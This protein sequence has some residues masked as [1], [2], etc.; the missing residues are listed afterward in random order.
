MSTGNPTP[1]EA[2][3]SPPPRRR[4]H[5]GRWL[6]WGL[7]GLL[8]LVLVLVVGALIYATGPAGEA[9]IRALAIEQA[10]KQLMGR[11]EIGGLDLSLR[12]LVLTGVKLYDPEGE[13]VAEIDRVEARVALAPLLRKHVVLQE[14]RVEQPHL[15]LH[16]DERGLN[17]SRAIE[18]R[19]P[20][21]EDPNAPR[22]T[23]RF[24]L[25]DLQ[26]TDGSVDYVAQ[27]PEGQR[28]VRL[29]DLDASGAASWASA[30]EALDAKLEATASLA[31][32]LAGPVRLSL[33]AGGQEGK[34]NADVDL[35]APGLTL[36]ANGGTEGENQARAEVKQLT[37]T[38]ETA[39]AFLPSYPV[40]AP[41]TL[42]GSVAQAG[43]TV[44]VNLEARAADGTAKVEGSLDTAKLRTDG[45]TAHVRG[46]DLAKLLGGGPST[47]LAADL[48]VRG[49]GKSLETLDGTVDLTL[50]P[51]S[52]DGQPLGPMELHASAKDGRF[53]L[54]QL[55]AQAPGVNLTARGGGTQED[56]R[57]EGRL[58]ASNLDAFA[59]TV[60]RLGNGQPL[61]LS[62]H[63]AVD[64][65]VTGPVRHPAVSLK[66]G[67]DTLA[68][69]DTSVQGLSL[70][71]R[72]PDVT[73]PL[74]TDA[75]LKASKL[76]TGGRTFEN[77]NASLLTRDR[78]LEASVTTGGATNLL[79]SLRGTVDKDNQGLGLD[80]LTLR[81]PEAEW[82]LQRPTHVDWGNGRIE[83]EPALS[84]ASGPQA[85]SLA[86]LM[87]GER[88]TARTE[89]RAF[90][91]GRLPKAFL[92]PTLDVAGQLSGQVAVNGRLPRPD[93]TVD[94]SLR[95]GRYQQYSD[96]AF[97]LKGRYVRDR[98]T[99]TF[100]AN[101]PA[102]RVSSTFDV[103]VQGLMLHRREPV[104]L[105][106]TAERVD[107]GPALRMAGQPESA[108]GILSGTL[109]LK[110]L[111]NDPR[112]A[113]ALKGEN[114]RY[115]GT[116]SQQHPPVVLA[117]GALP[118]QVGGEPLGIELTAR[119]D[120]QDATLSA[121]LDVHGIGSKASA[122]LVTPF[123]VG[124]LLAKPPTASQM[125]ETPMRQLQAELND[126][127][128]AL[129][130]QLGMADRAGGTVSMSAHL[131]GPLLAPVG[132][133]KLQARRATMNGLQPLDGEL[134]LRTDESSVK[135]QLAA[136]RESTLLA[137]VDAT[138]DAPIAA[139]QDQEV[140]GRVP[141][142]LAL[143]A[144]PISQRE[145]MGL[146]A[147]ATARADLIRCRTGATEDEEQLPDQQN[148]LSVS[149]RARGTLE[150][151]Q[152]DLTAG[153]QNIGVSQVG[154]GQARLHYTYDKARSEFTAQLASPK[155]GTL[156]ARGHATQ[157]LSLSAVRRGLD[158]SRAP[159]EVDVD[160]H[161]FDLSFLS[162]SRLP[163]VRSIGGVLAMDKVHVG[164][165]IGAPSFRGKLEWKDGRLALEGL[166]DYQKIHVALDGTDQRFE[167][168]DFSASSGGGNMSLKAKAERT[169]AEQFAFSGEGSLDDFPLVYDDQLL[170]L[171]QLRTHFEGEASNKLVNLRN[172]SIPEAHV[173]LPDAR[174]KD[175]QA[176]DRPEG[177]VLVCNGT[178]LQPT[179]DKRT[180]PPAGG[181][182]PGN[183]P[184]T[185]STTG[186]GGSGRGDTGEEP[187][188]QY[189]ININA[190]RNLWVNGSDVNAEIGLSE[191]FRV[192]YSTAASIY[193]EVRV[194]RGEVEVLGRRFNIQNSSQVR[195]T[196]P[197]LTPY[198][199]ATAE[200]N[201]EK[202]GVKVFVAV[203][204]QG[205]DFTIK[206]TSEPPLPETEIYTL[207]ATGRRTLHAGSGASMNQGQVASV[208]GS[209]LASQAR[210]ALAAKLPLDVLTIE[211]G[212]QGLSGARLEVGK[213]FTDELYVGYSGRLGAPQS[214]STTRRENANAVR[215]EYQF[216][217]RWSLEGEYGD[218][219]QGG[220]DVIWSKDY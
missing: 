136:R 145:L 167:L 13:L 205:K 14:A 210:K 21:P 149:L 84:L 51:S 28:E 186:T 98:A 108:T 170:A 15:Y 127:P 44:R 185:G 194:I 181:A 220:A 180:A 113:L 128:L 132:E 208:L 62:G 207:L 165:T 214:Q 4:R 104:S 147:A 54:S 17:L 124:Q 119:S 129:L 125:M 202:A 121:T 69:A 73:Q 218:A 63:G 157:E 134:A 152:M 27:A 151:P 197:A 178:P 191:N 146:S 39:R 79:V 133:V 172:L 198:I 49:G 195:F 190:P 213:Y 83:V 52:I 50:P 6:L 176:L 116:P 86:L 97:D 217:P 7:L 123:T 204:G 215:L 88:I 184:G 111:A 201:N 91:L 193:G 138:V 173:H 203:R 183:G 38:P 174:R 3:S 74:T 103:P 90:D 36:R 171:V 188:R 142:T 112:L 196:G 109:T 175:L 102:G 135:L 46:L 70:D 187:Q 166:G 68:W 77:L 106:L 81:Y 177:I 154:L 76:S 87:E 169:Q 85:L 18:P 80:A 33:T 137:Q 148:I 139:L 75:T 158:F 155:G 120:E 168:S 19:Q 100:A 56:V 2:P 144:G 192:E 115:W 64:F 117:P 95:G 47:V 131:T 58:V 161:Q 118:P 20:K 43:D 211:A 60:G 93:T 65:T 182:S 11:V 8:V 122:T 89:L 199:N 29:D 110:G 45:L 101:A 82:L 143:R 55:Q 67:F 156:L 32:P 40:A 24:T 92:P 126:M 164:G 66:G 163:M 105:E 153:V 114:L 189:W 53:E 22:G 10:N 25:E 140:V 107:I 179:K 1:P 30:T 219:Q 200:Y 78:A 99:G 5:P 61:P 41:V 31:R 162:G 96:L 150:E 216:S 160:A 12:S 159:L 209:V 35:D 72:V 23:L 141:F 16:Q 26:L 9:R 59:N 206:P 212:E 34:L 48:S 94:L 57:L 71:A 42:S 37:L 130:S